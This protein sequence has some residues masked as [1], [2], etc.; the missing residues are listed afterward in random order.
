MNKTSGITL[1]LSVSKH[2]QSTFYSNIIMTVTLTRNM[3]QWFQ[4]QTWA[5]VR[6]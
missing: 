3:F 6:S 5:V 2:Y 4:Q 1:P